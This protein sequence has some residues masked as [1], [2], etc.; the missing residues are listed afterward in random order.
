MKIKTFLAF[1]LFLSFSFAQLSAQSDT[2]IKVINKTV[3]FKFDDFGYYAP[4]YC[5][6]KIVD[7]LWGNIK[8]QYSDHIEKNFVKWE[9][10]KWD[11]ELTGWYGEVFQIHESDKIGI[12]NP[13]VYTFHF[14]LVGNMGNHY[15]NSGTYDWQTGIVTIDKAVCPGN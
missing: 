9:M 8:V 3:V 13:G 14:N 12:P 1:C 15:I 5:N 2:T 10:Y 4:I 6:G 7:L 11:G